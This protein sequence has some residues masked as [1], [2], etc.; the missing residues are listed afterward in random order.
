MAN[1]SNS[2]SFTPT[3]TLVHK[4]S[5]GEIYSISLPDGHEL[6]LIH[7]T[8]GSFRGGHSHSCAENVL[9]LSGGMKYHKLRVDGISFTENVEPGQV[10]FNAIGRIHM[11]EF[12]KDSWLI[13]YKFAKKGEWTQ[14]N[15]EPMREKVRASH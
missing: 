6:M 10:K 14:Q 3:L 13:E 8:P 12:Y 1:D 15:F 7:S 4:D 9:L 5:R 11:G 2:S